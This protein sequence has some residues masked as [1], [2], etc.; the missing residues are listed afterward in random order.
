MTAGEQEKPATG[1]AVATSEPA[2]FVTFYVRRDKAEPLFQQ[3]DSLA[4]QTPEAMFCGGQDPAS[5][6]LL[7]RRDPPAAHDAA[8]IRLIL[9]AEGDAATAWETL[10]QRLK[11]MLDALDIPAEWWGYT[12]VYQAVLDEDMDMETAFREL[13]PVVRRPHSS[14]SLRRPLAI[15][16]VSGGR[17]WLMDVPLRGD[18]QAAATVMVALSPPDKEQALKGELFGTTLSMADLIAHKGYSIRREYRGDRQRNYKNKLEAFREYADEL[19]SDLGRQIQEQGK[20]DEVAGWYGSL[21]GVIALFS[22][23]SISTAQQLHNYERWRAQT[24][25]NGIIEYHYGHLE[26]ANRELELLVAEGR[27]ALEVADKALSM[28]RVELDRDQGNRR[29]LIEYLLAVVGAALA[30]PELVNRN[31]A[32]ALLVWFEWKEPG[33]LFIFLTQVAAIAAAAVLIMLSVRLVSRWR[34]G[35]Q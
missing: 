16:D 34:G 25:S 35:V 7:G 23:T 32:E 31:A 29:R 17:V 5:K 28:A 27:D 1:A 20:L 9:N 24:R 21:T 12:V 6:P 14:E 18:G 30:V 2:L 10:R 33:Y 26:T 22:K 13:L 8:A 11:N 3:L 4:R 15:A 19:L